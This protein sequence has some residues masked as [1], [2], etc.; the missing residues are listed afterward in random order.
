V[1]DDRTR[2]QAELE[3][4]RDLWHGGYFVA[5]PGQTLAPYL[6][7]SMMGHFHVIYLACVRPW[8]TPRTHVLE[9]GCGR[10]A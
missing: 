5:D 8:I 2:L 3:S 4:F 6:L 1:N 7:Q 10:G 9:I